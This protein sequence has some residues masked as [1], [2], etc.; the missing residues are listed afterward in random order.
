MSNANPQD[1]FEITVRDHDFPMALA[2]AHPPVRTLFGRGCRELITKMA[3][4]PGLAIVGSRQASPQG[5][6]D[7]HWYAKE[8]SRAGLTIIS[9]L[10]QGIDASAHKGGLEGGGNT[11]A[12]LGHGLQSIYPSQHQPLS[13]QILNGG[14]ALVS[15]YPWGTPAL[16]HHFPQRNRIIAGLARA[17]LIV[18]A[19]PQS[20]SLITA[21]H[22]L[23]LGID[24]FVVPGSIHMPQSLGCNALIRQ[25]AQLSQSPEQLL[26]DLGVTPASSTA[27]PAP[28]RGNAPSQRQLHGKSANRRQQPLAPEL[29]PVA[30]KVLAAL[31]FHPST[32][33]DLAAQSQLDDREIYGA[34][35]ILELCGLTHRTPDG[36]WLKQRLYQ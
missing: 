22:A 17:I 4:Q 32:V 29:D 21:R 35:L 16:P 19:T 11:I 6:A 36:K 34:L 31:N 26:D 14:G 20:G 25:G 1:V 33:S 3:L 23:D 15:E 9:G 2:Q 10:A 27:K 5:L 7:A 18:E 24:V 12:V 13:E 8:A 30:A 28:K